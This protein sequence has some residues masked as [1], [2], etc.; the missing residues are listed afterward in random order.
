MCHV[1]CYFWC[2]EIW[3][4]SVCFQVPKQNIILITATAKS[5]FSDSVVII[6]LC[7]ADI[8][9]KLACLWFTCISVV[10]F[11]LP[12]GKIQ[13]RKASGFSA[14]SLADHMAWELQST[15]TY[16]HGDIFILFLQQF[17]NCTWKRQT[18]AVTNVRTPMTK[19]LT[20]NLTWEYLKCSCFWSLSYRWNMT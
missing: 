19:D 4:S 8:L 1:L 9:P 14:P 3:S 7:N 13:V 2:L 18:C 5:V 16:V 15:K 17:S 12:S 10:E 11:L 20:H 6:V